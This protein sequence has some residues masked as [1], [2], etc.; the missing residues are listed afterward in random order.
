MFFVEEFKIIKIWWIFST[1]QQ[2]LL[3][4]VAKLGYCRQ[5]EESF[6]IFDKNPY[7]KSLSKD[8]CL[9]SK[10]LD[11]WKIC[12]VYYNNS[13]GLGGVSPF[14]PS[15]HYW[16]MGYCFIFTSDSIALSLFRGKALL[17]ST[18]QCSTAFSDNILSTNFHQVQMDNWHNCLVPT[19]F[20]TAFLVPI[21]SLCRCLYII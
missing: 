9:C 19:V 3:T 11:P 14:P 12:P 2:L 7:E 16:F 13:S 1:M 6:E 8:F 4:H 18:Q 17:V 21:L 10:S 20:V 5:N 15:R